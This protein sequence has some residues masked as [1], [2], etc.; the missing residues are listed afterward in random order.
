V[1]PQLRARTLEALMLERPAGRAAALL[2]DQAARISGAS[3]RMARLQARPGSTAG[4]GGPA[5][6]ERPW[7]RAGKR[8]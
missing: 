2:R 5:P 8:S 7:I 4:P 1:L 6:R 3:A